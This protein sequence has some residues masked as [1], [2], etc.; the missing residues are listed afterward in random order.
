LKQALFLHNTIYINTCS[1][2]P[3]QQSYTNILDQISPESTFCCLLLMIIYLE[4]ANF[5]NKVT[6]A[7]TEMEAFQKVTKI[8]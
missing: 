5:P 7:V 2:Q 4:S 1:K 8:I 3:L 6:K